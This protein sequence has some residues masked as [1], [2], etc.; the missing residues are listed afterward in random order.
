MKRTPVAILL[1]LIITAFI[2]CKSTEKA[3]KISESKKFEKENISSVLQA[4]VIN[5]GELTSYK[6]V[7]SVHL[8]GTEPV[9]ENEAIVKVFNQTMDST[10]F[11]ISSTDVFR[12]NLKDLGIPETFGNE[13]KY[14]LDFLPNPIMPHSYRKD[15]V[16]NFIELFTLEE[17]DKNE[18]FL[19]FTLDKEKFERIAYSRNVLFDELK[20]ITMVVDTQTSNIREYRFTFEE[21][22]SPFK[23]H[24][25][26]FDDYRSA[27]NL[28]YPSK[29]TRTTIKKERPEKQENMVQL[30]IIEN[31]KQM[32]NYKQKKESCIKMAEAAEKEACIK[33][34]ENAIRSLDAMNKMMAQNIYSMEYDIEIKDIRSR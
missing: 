13:M 14:W 24:I 21:N 4:A 18:R 32:E 9:G 29:I 17:K 22:A 5:A 25:I 2:G 8:P 20:Q 11:T 12:G 34:W 31:I 3:K 26:I 15:R 30:E 28:S 1:I 33:K 6:L 16:D 10:E 23:E 19:T 27:K 7:R